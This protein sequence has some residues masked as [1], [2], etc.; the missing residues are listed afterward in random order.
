MSY[1]GRH[2]PKP[3]LSGDPV[4]LRQTEFSRSKLSWR[5]AKLANRSL[6]LLE[7]PWAH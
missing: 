1:Q 5:A 6:R 3:K 4:G 2:R 7:S